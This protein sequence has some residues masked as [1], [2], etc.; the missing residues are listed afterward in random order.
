MATPKEEY[1][2]EIM[3]FLIKHNCRHSTP[4]SSKKLPESAIRVMED[5]E[6]YT[7]RNVNNVTMDT[8]FQFPVNINAQ[9]KDANVTYERKIASVILCRNNKIIQGIYDPINNQQLC[10]FRFR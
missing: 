5:E 1:F 2:T 4:L 6:K 7:K 10:I 3:D 9:E 8:L